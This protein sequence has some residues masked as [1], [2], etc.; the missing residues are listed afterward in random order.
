MTFYLS[1]SW[2]N[3]NPIP[4]DTHRVPNKELVLVEKWSKLGFPILSYM[5]K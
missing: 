1:I 5:N 4:K 3:L 2:D